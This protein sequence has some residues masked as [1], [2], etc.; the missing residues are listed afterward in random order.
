MVLKRRLTLVLLLLLTALAYSRILDAPFVFDDIPRIQGPLLSIWTAGRPLSVLLWRAGFELTG[1]HSFG[2]HLIG[3]GLHLINVAIVFAILLALEIELPWAFC[4]AAVFGLHPLMTQAVTY[5]TGNASALC[6]VFYFA[7]LYLGIRWCKGREVLF[8]PILILYCLL[9]AWWTKPEAVALPLILAVTA[10][11]VTNRKGVLVAGFVTVALLGGWLVFAGNLAGIGRYAPALAIPTNAAVMP[12]YFLPQL[13][14][15]IHQSLDPDV[16]IIGVWSARFI[17]ASV[18]WVALLAVPFLSRLPVLV[19]LGVACLAYAPWLPRIAALNQAGWIEEHHAYIP[20]VGVAILAAWALQTLER[21]CRTFDLEIFAFG[22]VGLLSMLTLY[23]N[24]LWRS[25]LKLWQ[26]A[27]VQAKLN[28]R[29]H[30]AYATELIKAGQ[31]EKAPSEFIKAMQIDR[32]YW[33]AQNNLAVFAIKRKDL[34]VAE[35]L[36]RDLTARAPSYAEG[37]TTL[38]YLRIQQGRPGDAGEAFDKAIALDNSPI[39]NLNKA[40]LLRSIGR[41]KEAEPYFAVA[42]AARPDLRNLR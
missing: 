8:T 2:S 30:N 16:P 19:R 31:T 34:D 37:F 24:E 33:D 17:L 12:L 38:G 21:R 26:N 1:L 36:L 13:M 6:A 27:A 15:P 40:E 29:P 32:E 14:L 7:A 18:I 3:I 22:M 20:M 42:F 10:Y 11:I 39:A 41:K 23:R 9:F 35:A 4:G 25:P 5:T 28:P